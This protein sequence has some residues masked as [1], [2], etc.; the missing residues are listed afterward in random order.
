MKFNTS[1]LL[2]WSPLALVAATLTVVAANQLYYKTSAT[3]EVSLF[4][5]EQG[6]FSVQTKIP[7]FQV[8]MRYTD[9]GSL[10]FALVESVTTNSQSYFAEGITGQVNIKVRGGDQMKNVLWSKT[11]DSTDVSYE[12][13]IDSV[14]T[15]LAGCCSS[16]DT[17]RAYDL[18]TGKLLISYQGINESTWTRNL[19]LLIEVP[20]SKL[21]KRMIGVITQDSTR[22][23]DFV[24]P[25]AGMS[26]AVLIKYAG[27]GTNFQ[28]VQIDT[29]VAQNYGVS[30]EVKLVTFGTQEKMPEIR[31]GKA[32]LWNADGATSAAQIGGVAL[33]ITVSAGLG[34]KTLILPILQDQLDVGSTMVPA[35]LVIRKLQ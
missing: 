21:S 24:A 28:K 9:A 29:Q 3:A 4:K 12:E 2:K 6:Q 1:S 13:E 27:K 23:T 34:E 30:T 8:A 17:H 35:G 7:K 11:E 26:A 19:P 18:A 33:E 15:T 22:D 10:P 14:V 32:T 20:N 16:I 5:N 31:D 25:T